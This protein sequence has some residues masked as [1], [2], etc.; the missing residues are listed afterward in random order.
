M[1]RVALSAEQEIVLKMS[2]PVQILEVSR[3]GVQFMS[4]NDVA[5]GDRAEL[6]ATIGGESFSMAV[7]VRH[8][9]VDPQPRGGVVHR[10]GAVFVAASAHERR[11]IDRL[12]G[13]ESR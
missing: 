4:R 11:L 6:I 3:R 13:V 8:V 2:I 1:P 10:A 5:V 12:L 7:E 9:S